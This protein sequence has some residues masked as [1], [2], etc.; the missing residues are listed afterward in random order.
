M[1][2]LPTAARPLCS[3]LLSLVSSCVITAAYSHLAP[4]PTLSTTAH[5]L[6]STPL[7]TP[8]RASPCLAVPPPPHE[9]KAKRAVR[10]QAQDAGGHSRHKHATAASDAR[11]AQAQVAQ[12]KAALKKQQQ[13]QQ[14]Q[15]QQQQQR[16]CTAPPAPPT[17]ASHRDQYQQPPTTGPRSMMS[18]G[19]PTNVRGNSNQPPPPP[20]TGGAYYVG[21]GHGGPTPQVNMASEAFEMG[22]DGDGHAAQPLPA[23]GIINN[24]RN[25]K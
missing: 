3:A 16:P 20:S 17:M 19:P 18:R 12:N 24:P 1:E 10:H 21:H 5:M 13:E 25:F 23:P 9:A 22:D 4:L 6:L 15:R 8:L 14:E 7:H 2:C 11:Q